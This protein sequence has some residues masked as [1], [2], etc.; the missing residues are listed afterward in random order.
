MNWK[1]LVLLTCCGIGRLAAQPLS[2][3]C[4]TDIL[5]QRALENPLFR[6]Q[7]EAFEGQAL[8]F[9][10]NPK[11]GATPDG[12][13]VTLP[14]VVHI[15]HNNGAENISDAQVLQGIQ[16][17]NEA[18]ANIGYYDQGTGTNTMIQFCLAKRDPDNQTTTGITRNQ[19]PLTDMTIESDNLS[20]KDLNRWDPTR[21]INLWVVREMC[22]VFAGCGVAGYSNFPSEHGSN[23]DGAVVEATWFGTSPGNSG[24]LVHELGH[25]LGLYHTFQDGCTNNDCLTDGDRVCDTP[26]DKSTAWVPCN[27]VVN[28]CSTDAQSG[29][30]SDQNDM[31]LN[32]MDYTDFKCFHDF[33]PGQSARMNY[34]LQTLRASLL[35]SKGCFDPCPT[36]VLAAFSPSSA[37]IAIGQNLAF[38]NASQNASGY[39]WSIGG[40]PF[41]TALNASYTF[42]AEGVFVVVLRAEGL[43]SNGCGADTASAIIQVVCPVVADFEASTINPSIGEAVSFTNNSQQAAQFEWFIDGVSQGPALNSHV[44]SQVGVYIVRLEASNGFCKRTTFKY[45]SVADSCQN[46]TFQKTWG[47]A[48]DNRGVQTAVLSDGNFIQAGESA[49]AGSGTDIVLIKT[50]PNGAEIWQ[51]RFGG[52]GNEGVRAI[53]PLPDGGWVLAGYSSSMGSNLDPLVVRFAADGT[54]LWQKIMITAPDVDYFTDVKKTK[55]GQLILGGGLHSASNVGWGAYLGKLNLSNGNVIWAHIYD[56]TRTDFIQSVSEL[57]SGDFA[58]CGFTMSFGQNASIVHDGMLMRTDALGNL[59]WVKAIGSSDNEWLTHVFETSDGNLMAV[60]STSG[61]NGPGGGAYQ[62]DAWIVKTT[63]SGNVLSSMVHNCDKNIDYGAIGI[64]PYSDGSIV[65]AA[66]DP[67]TIGANVSQIFKT[68]PNGELEWSHLFQANTTGRILDIAAL[69]DGYLCSGYLTVNG[70]PDLYLLKTNQDGLAGD[71]PDLPHI[72]SSSTVQ[73]LVVDGQL[74]TLPGPGLQNANLVT[75]SIDFADSLMCPP[76]CIQDP[77]PCRSFQ[78]AYGTT[79]NDRGIVGIEMPGGGYLLGGNTTQNGNQML[80]VTRTDASGNVMWSKRYDSP[81]QPDAL[82]DL[83]AKPDGGFFISFTLANPSD[84]A[85]AVCDPNGNVL[86]SRRITTNTGS[87]TDVFYDIIATADGGYLAAGAFSPVNESFWASFFLKMDATGATQWYRS[88]NETGTDFVTGV[89]EL[90]GGGY[91]ASGYG[92]SFGLAGV[93]D[94]FAY[95]LDASG[96]LLWTKAY[97]TPGEGGFSDV[98]IAADG[99]FLF[100]AGLWNFGNGNAPEGGIVRTDANGNLLW[101]KL[102]RPSNNLD[103]ETAGLVNT[104]DGNFVLAG[105]NRPNTGDTKAYLLKLN[106][107][108]DLLWTRQYGGPGLETLFDVRA[109]TSGEL[110]WTGRTTSVGSGGE[111]FYVLKTDADG[112][113]GLCPQTPHTTATIPIQF[114]QTNGSLKEITPPVLTNLSLSAVDIAVIKTEICLPDCTEDPPCEDTWIKTFPT[115]NL[116]DGGNNMIQ[117]ADGNFII[118]GFRNDSSLLMKMTPAGAVLWARSFKFA[119]GANERINQLIEDSEG[120]I[121][122]CGLSGQ[123]SLRG[124]TFR[125]NPATNLLDWIQEPPANPQSFCFAIQE[126]SP[127]GNFVA[128]YSH[129]NSPAP[130]SFDD[131]NLVELSRNTGAIT[132]TP[133]AFSFGSSESVLD[134]QQRGG[135]WYTAGRYT[136]GNTFG[137]MRAALSCFDQ[138]GNALWSRMLLF[139]A[140]PTARNYASDFT[141][142]GSDMV[143]TIYGDFGGDQASI[144][145]DIGICKTNASGDILWAKR[146]TMPLEQALPKSIITVSDGYIVLVANQSATQTPGVYLMKVDKSGNFLWCREYRDFQITRGEK[147][148]AVAGNY[149]YFTAQHLGD[150]DLAVAKINLSNGLLGGDCVPAGVPVSVADLPTLS[151]PVN[152]LRY[153]SPLSQAPRTVSGFAAVLNPSNL[154]FKSCSPEICNNGLDDDGDNLF[155]C[156]DSDCDCHTCDGSETDIWYFGRRAGLDFSTDPPQVLTNGNTNTNEASAVMSDPLGQLIFYTDARTIFQRTHTAMPNGTGLFGHTSSSQTV[157]VPHPG[158]PAQFYVFTPDSYDNGPQHAVSYSVVDMSLNFGLGDVPAGQKNLPLT[159]NGELVEQLCAVRH[160]NGTDFWLLNHRKNS[161]AFMAFL[162]DQN[163]LDLNAVYSNT[164][165]G[166]PAPNGNF[167]VIGQMKISPDG[168]RLARALYHTNAVEVFDFDAATGVVSNPLLLKLPG[169]K[170]PYGVEFSASGRYLYATGL[171][172]PSSLYQF[173]LLA[174]NVAASAV[175][176]ASFPGIYHYGQ[177]QLAK[178]GKIY[179]TNSG[180]GQFTTQLGVIHLPEVAG[181]GSLYQEG[182]QSLTGTPGTNLSLPNFLVNSFWKP[183]IWFDQDNL[184]DT[185]CQLP[186]E[187]TFSLKKLPCGVLSVDWA[188]SGTGTITGQ[189]RETVTVRFDQPGQAQIIAHANSA[190]GEAADTLRLTVLQPSAAILELGPDRVLCNNEV[191]VLDAGPGFHQYRWHDGSTE[192]TVTTTLAPGKY[193]VDV[194]DQCGNKQSDT[195]EIGVTPATVLDLG[196]DQAACSGSSFTYQLPAPFTAWHWYP[197]DHLSCDDCPTVISAAPANMSYI[198]VAESAGGCFSADTIAIQIIGDTVLMPVQ[199]TTCTGEQAVWNGQN[200]PTGGPYPFVFDGTNGCDSTVMVTV[201]ELDSVLQ[202]LQLL[203][204][205]G[206]PASWNG[207]DLPPGGPY[208]FTF[209]AASG[210][211]STLLITVWEMDSVQT[212]VQ[213]SACPGE[214]AAWNGQN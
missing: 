140:G 35:E 197:A 201:L 196:P 207:Q 63:P 80:L 43:A 193:W 203:T 141:F 123:G 61:W 121:A 106:D 76:G 148:L 184:D 42:P 86:F 149:L 105:R 214:T 117:A 73:P 15:I 89:R 11:P 101:T 82:F 91:I 5:L 167:D 47:D 176:L 188:I 100:A 142:D 74:S 163:G 95:R 157:I 156:L 159:P 22:S 75:G 161:Q 115:P 93:H 139:G 120:H 118:G 1:T 34:S 152:L 54:V 174:P 109:L 23:N 168:S 136:Y 21:Y 92:T 189:T 169:L 70:T 49:V 204:C 71:C 6:A 147:L 134:L 13:V 153:P 116:Q 145:P 213:L 122:G 72:M 178:N 69:P 165:T 102:Y 77:P 67:A 198:I 103:W 78:N 191:T 60:G 212:Q 126:K 25:Y 9:F 127:G 132:G 114:T 56:N 173:D 210:C 112:L 4:G 179:T 199:L 62:D 180:P 30:S 88:W 130:G 31:I 119:S 187:Q 181:A 79:D 195:L 162:I 57:P 84:A 146:F 202:T 192:Q 51:K 166:G 44:F 143:T 125:Y 55:D 46:V 24:V 14:V 131:A 175:A 108:G 37:T 45:I 39:S 158:N 186:L 155:D 18:Y 144:T 200:L 32:F 170:N 52:P 50:A 113:A 177:L 90:P 133:Y 38:T 96:N 81:G 98:A 206:V 58:A 194:W 65:W 182:G 12:A 172:N 26:P 27:A 211:D 16:H 110:L 135:L 3:P 66:N 48:S 20:L 59:T 8:Q 154:C 94:G 41:S 10:R 171:S 138:L 28:S 83:Q 87:F 40:V 33:T 205:I 68:Y 104:P 160:C 124:F 85:F 64:V 208:P 150:G 185:L 53:E 151:S 129:H 7:H 36:P 164:G 111:D 19:S 99:G 97:G 137:G 190:C 128:F 29:F 2:E 107:A 183:A 17:L 209:T